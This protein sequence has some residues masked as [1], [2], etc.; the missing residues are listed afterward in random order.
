[1]SLPSKLLIEFIKEGKG[2]RLFLTN[3]HISKNY[4]YDYTRF[5]SLLN[6]VNHFFDFD[7]V[8]EKAIYDELLQLLYDS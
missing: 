4:N 5:I 2:Y 6:F 3:P 1:M 7:N 8:S